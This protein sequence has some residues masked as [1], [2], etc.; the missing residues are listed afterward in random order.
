MKTP[1]LPRRPVAAPLLLALAACSRRIP[2]L[3]PFEASVASVG[4]PEIPSPTLAAADS[5]NPIAPE[6]E[7]ND[8]HTRFELGPLPSDAPF[9]GMLSVQ[10]ASLGPDRAEYA[11]YHFALKGTKAR[12]DLFAEGGKGDPTG[13]RLYD[14]DA[15]KFYTVVRQPVLYTTDERDL[16]RETGGLKTWQF[17]PFRLEPK[18]IVDNVGCNRV[19][20]KDGEFDYDTCLASGIPTIPWQ[21]LG[22]GMAQAV[23]FGA[24]LQKKGLFPLSVVVRRSRLSRGTAIRPVVATLTVLRIERGQL[25]ERAFELPPFPVSDTPTLVPPRL[26]R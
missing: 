20:T 16:L 4:V 13:Y 15:H 23:P 14:G 12:W 1:L 11:N 19:Q 26:V 21:L 22:A 24:A 9:E 3:L 25:P 10:V 7:A 2:E 6:A 5:L 18:A 17:T 8:K